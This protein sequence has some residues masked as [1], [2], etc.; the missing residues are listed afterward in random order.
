M[1]EQESG[2]NG[3]KRKREREGLYKRVETHYK[4]IYR[5]PYL[6]CTLD[7]NLSMYSRKVLL[8]HIG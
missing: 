1:K 6:P 7:P 3:Q 5:Y 2:G 4:H 8:G